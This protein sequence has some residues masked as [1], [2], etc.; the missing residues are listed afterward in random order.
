MVILDLKD[1]EAKQAAEEIKV[2]YGAWS[3]GSCARYH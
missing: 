3:K 1:S 2:S